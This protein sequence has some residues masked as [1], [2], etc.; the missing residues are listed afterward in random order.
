VKLLLTSS[1]VRNGSIRDALLRLLGKPIE[2][3]AALV[4]PTAIH[5]F[6][7]GPEMAAR[8]IRGEVRTPLT[9]LGWSSLGVLE[10]TALP[11]IDRDVWLPTVQAADA[12]L[13]WG[14]DPLYLSHWLQQS[15][16]AELL[17]S[18]SSV[19]VGV[20]AGAMAACSTIG[21]TYTEPPSGSCSPLSSEDMVFST[22]DGDVSRTFV[23]AAGAGL[24]DVALIP[25]FDSPDHPD[26]SPANAEQWAA[27]LPLPT[28]AID[29]ETALV[30]TDGVVD[31]VSEGTWRLFPPV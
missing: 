19:Y 6:S 10:L 15:G 7:S 27:K 16:L 13:F 18:L 5:P 8:L 25:H 29:D 20:S 14:G 23:T 11:S 4:V 21:E 28:Y 31:V 2:E 26:A 1:G 30:V 9:E 24:V 22:P 17:P 12:L 3:S